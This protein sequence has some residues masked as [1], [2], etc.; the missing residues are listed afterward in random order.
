MTTYILLALFILAAVALIL[1]LRIRPKGG[2]VNPERAAADAQRFAKLLIAEIKIYN[3][4]KLESACK[5]GNIYMELE[6]E[7]ERARKMY[8]DRVPPEL[9]GHRDYFHE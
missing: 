8:V 7:I 9:I 6:S 5:A 4:H 2:V 3:E 1:L